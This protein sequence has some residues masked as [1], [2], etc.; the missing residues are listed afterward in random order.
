MKNIFM[1][2]L[3]CM[4]LLFVACST[5]NNTQSSE[6]PT[7]LVTNPIVLDTVFTS[8]YVTTLQSIQAVELRPRLKGVLDKILVDEGD[9]VQAGQLLFQLNNPE[10]SASLMKVKAQ[11]KM[12]VAEKKSAVIELRNAQKLLNNKIISA[13]EVEMLEAKI[14]GIV[15]RVEELEV[16]ITNFKTQLGFTQIKAPFSGVINRIPFKVGAF[17]DENVVLTKIYNNKEMYAYF[18]LSEVEYLH[19]LAESQSGHPQNV[20]LILANGGKYRHTGQIETTDAEFNLSTGNIAFRAKF[21][22]PEKLLKSGSSGKIQIPQQF[23][24]ALIIPQKATFEVQDKTFVYIVSPQGQI[25]TK[26][27][28]ILSRQNK[29]YI[30][31]GLK[32]ADQFIYEGIQNVKEGDAIVTK[33]LNSKVILQALNN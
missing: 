24:N 12:V 28:K 29:L 32:K 33:K 15:A 25:E 3:F 7:F 16:E 8:E 22:N 9:E 19:I 30:I 26:A 11:L 23:K 17:V 4:H 20:G 1:C 5:K 21:K 13:S 10:I 31:E 18:N 14:D 6:K 2:I 27:I